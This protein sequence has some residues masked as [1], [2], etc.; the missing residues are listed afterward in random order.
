MDKPDSI[1]FPKLQSSTLICTTE[2]ANLE[3]FIPSSL[4]H[5]I[6]RHL[7]LMAQ[8]LGSRYFRAQLVI[9]TVDHGI[10]AESYS[11][12]LYAIIPSYRS[13]YRTHILRLSLRDITLL[14]T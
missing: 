6:N 13:I 1:A 3:S 11:A 7:R 2:Y 8:K 5:W 9:L 14:L 4:C 10:N 12:S